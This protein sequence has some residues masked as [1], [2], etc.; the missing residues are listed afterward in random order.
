MKAEA[1]ANAEADK[2]EKERIDKLNQADSLIFP[3]NG[4][5]H[6][7]DRPELRRSSRQQSESL[8]Q[9]DRWYLPAWHKTQSE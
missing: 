1:E 9:D 5:R 7:H 4:T 3:E 6:A 2:K 8:C